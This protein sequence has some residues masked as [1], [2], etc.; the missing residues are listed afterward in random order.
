MDQPHFQQQSRNSENIVLLPVRD[1]RG[2]ILK[3]VPLEM[4]QGPEGEE[5]RDLNYQCFNHPLVLREVND[6]RHFALYS[7]ENS[8]LGFAT[9]LALHHGAQ[10][11]YW[12]S[13]VCISPAA[14]GYG[15]GRTL[16]R[17]V[18]KAIDLTAYSAVVGKGSCYLATS[19]A[20]GFFARCGFTVCEQRKVM[21]YG[22]LKV[23]AKPLL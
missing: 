10:S 9:L 22:T 18:L 8:P 5:L 16:V 2:G 12:L 21:P 17:S 19:D 11:T 4:L 3:E 23:M 1:L 20:E 15:L 14:R 6:Y 13:N 7:P